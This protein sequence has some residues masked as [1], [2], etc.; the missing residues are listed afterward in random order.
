MIKVYVPYGSVG[1]TNWIKNKKLVNTIEEADLV[2]LTGGEDCDPSSYGE[3]AGSYT[4]WN[5]RR[6]EIES[7][8]IEKAIALGK[9]MFGTC[10]GLQ[11][12]CIA[13]G[14]K[15]IQDMD[16]PGSHRILTKDGESFSVNSLH[17]QAIYPFDLPKDKYEILAET[18]I[19][20]S[21]HY[22]NG[23][24]NNIDVPTEVEAAYFPE[25]KAMGV[26]YHPE[27]MFTGEITP[28]FSW[29]FDEINKNLNLQIK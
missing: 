5:N 26:Q 10:K 19:K 9:P 27:M 1:Y 3:K 25:I 18:P 21:P 17:H 8:A 22:L 11:M 13:A 24:D 16:H 7:E 29:L 2:F 28:H 20:L 23:D 6:E 15:L 12:L 14:G 4:Y